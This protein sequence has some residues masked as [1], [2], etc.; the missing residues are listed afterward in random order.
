MVT[1]PPNRPPFRRLDEIVAL[2]HAVVPGGG[3]LAPGESGFFGLLIAHA[4]PAPL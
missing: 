3:V 2:A 4:G 1:Q